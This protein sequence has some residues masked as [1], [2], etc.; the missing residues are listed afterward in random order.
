MAVVLRQLNRIYE[1]S[2][3]DSNGQIDRVFSQVEES[4]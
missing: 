2:K 4:R 3:G 1:S